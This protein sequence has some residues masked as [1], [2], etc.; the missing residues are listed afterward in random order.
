[1]LWA[2][3]DWSPCDRGEA[4]PVPLDETHTAD[5]LDTAARRSVET[6]CRQFLAFNREDLGEIDAAQAGHDFYLT[7][8]RH[9]AGFWDRGLGAIGDRLTAAAQVYGDSGEYVGD[10][11][12][13][14]V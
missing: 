11:G 3:L 6:D 8:N 13:I 10:D 7:R 5:D 14:Y 9:G 12:R 2:G 1:M 4:N